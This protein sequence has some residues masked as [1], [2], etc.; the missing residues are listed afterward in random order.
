MR[1]KRRKNTI[2]KKVVKAKRT[3]RTSFYRSDERNYTDPQY[4]KWRNEVKNRD[5]KKCRFPGCMSTKRLQ[6][7][8]I[9][10]WADYPTLRFD[11][12]NGITL[13]QK[14]HKL[15]T[16]QEVFFEALFLKILEWDL[17]EELKKGINKDG[18]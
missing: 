10:K 8:H 13:C 5:K 9:R 1:K 6:V 3:K 7:H 14:C 11:I 2:K 4:V 15:V 12:T 18:Q 16:G 17:I